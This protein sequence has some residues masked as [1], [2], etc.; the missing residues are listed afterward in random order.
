MRRIVEPNDLGKLFSNRRNNV[1]WSTRAQLY[2][3]QTVMT[4]EQLCNRASNVLTK[5]RIHLSV[6]LKSIDTFSV[7]L[8]LCRRTRRL[9]DPP[10]FQLP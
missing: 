8:Y 7:N 5:N 2:I 10:P 1:N 3:F 9:I 6:G 4:N